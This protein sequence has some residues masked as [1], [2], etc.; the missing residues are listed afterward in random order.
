MLWF[1]WK[2]NLVN[3]E[4]GFNH[5]QQEIYFH[6]GEKIRIFSAPVIIIRTSNFFWLDCS[7]Q[8][9]FKVDFFCICVILNR[10]VKASR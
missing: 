7:L 9:I 4:L 1:I 10:V 2:C 5:T 3:K 8:I 6:L